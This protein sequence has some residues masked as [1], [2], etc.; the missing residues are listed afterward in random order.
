MKDRL[1]NTMG[2]PRAGMG[3]GSAR[4]GM[5]YPKNASARTRTSIDRMNADSAR[6]S[7]AGNRAKRRAATPKEA[8][9]SKPGFGAEGQRMLESAN[10]RRVVNTRI[11]AAKRAGKSAAMNVAA[12]G[13][14]TGGL[15]AA[16]RKSN[17]KVEERKMSM[18]AK[19][20]TAAMRNM[21]KGR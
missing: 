20:K 13:A 7:M 9:E 5:K 4:G 19:R 14:V 1:T 3:S 16:T 17:T 21:K 15:K 12:A 11:S 8:Y 2:A 6:R 10:R 18:Q